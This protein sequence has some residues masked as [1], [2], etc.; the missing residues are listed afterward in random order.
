MDTLLLTLL[1]LS[2]LELLVILAMVY[3]LCKH[4]K[5]LDNQRTELM[6]QRARMNT[7]IDK[8][9]PIRSRA[10]PFVPETPDVSFDF[11]LLDLE[12]SL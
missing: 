6:K 3:V 11:S 9:N 5:I 4:S 2:I 12:D 8:S 1:T 7:F 10:S